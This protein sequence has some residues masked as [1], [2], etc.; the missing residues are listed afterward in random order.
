MTH[1]EMRKFSHSAVL[2]YTN[3][4]AELQLRHFALLCGL[5]QTD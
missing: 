5:L 4:G 2:P 3:L 1:R